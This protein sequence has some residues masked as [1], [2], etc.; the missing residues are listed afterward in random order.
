[1]SPAARQQWLCF[2]QLSGGYNIDRIGFTRASTTSG[3]AAHA[4]A[5]AVGVHRNYLT[6]PPPSARFARFQPDGDADALD[7]CADASSHHAVEA[8]ARRLALRLF[9]RRLIRSLL[10]KPFRAGARAVPGER[11]EMLGL[12][13]ALLIDGL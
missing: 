11:G 4:L 3:G 5:G 9:E 8:S 6:N 2:V 13:N 10:L 7:A 12:A 1:V